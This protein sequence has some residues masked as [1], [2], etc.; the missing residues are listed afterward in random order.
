[1]CFA[2]PVLGEFYRHDV[3][4]ACIGAD[5]GTRERNETVIYL[6]SRDRH[7]GVGDAFRRV[8]IDDAAAELDWFRGHG[9]GRIR[10]RLGESAVA[11][12]R[13]HQ[14][15]SEKQAAAGG[16]RGSLRH[17]TRNAAGAS[18]GQPLLDGHALGEIPWLVDVAPAS[19]RHVI[20]Q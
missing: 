20:R 19:H 7:G 13:Q 8:D 5:N 3:T 2:A 6:S 11:R 9:W 4:A 1:V 10:G 18:I 16:R 17:T 14:D 12:V 15:H